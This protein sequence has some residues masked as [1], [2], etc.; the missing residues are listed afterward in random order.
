[1]KLSTDLFYFCSYA[2]ALGLDS[3]QIRSYPCNILLF[4]NVGDA[5]SVWSVM[6]ESFA[7]FV[8]IAGTWCVVCVCF[9]VRFVLIVFCILLT[10]LRKF[11][12]FCVSC[13][14]V[15]VVRLIPPFHLLCFS[16]FV[17]QVVVPSDEIGWFWL[18]CG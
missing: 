6:M 3:Q 17:V 9:L 13:I 1:M 14:A 4:W 5:E 8:V 16:S 2:N 7:T 10:C 15:V 18:G 12:P 11:L